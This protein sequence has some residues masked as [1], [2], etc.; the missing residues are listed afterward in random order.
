MPLKRVPKSALFFLV[1]LLSLV[2]CGS[3]E[4]QTLGI[5]A[6]TTTVSATSPTT[7]A[8]TTAPITSPATATTPPA[9]TQAATTR[10]ASTTA[11]KTT[12]A[13]P[14]AA[15]KTT[16]AS[17]TAAVKP[18]PTVSAGNGSGKLVIENVNREIEL[19]APGGG[20]RVLA[21]G[22]ATP[23]WSPD[24]K[25][26]AYTTLAN[27]GGNGHITTIKTIKEDGTGEETL[28]SGPFG[29]EPTWLLRW[30]PRGRYIAMYAR[31]TEIQDT[32]GQLVLCDV[33][34]KKFSLPLETAQGKPN[35]VFDWIPDG[36]FAFWQAGKDG[37]YNL[38]YGDPDKK[39]VDAIKLL[40]SQAI[41]SVN[42]NGVNGQG[43]FTSARFSP[44]GRTIAVAANQIGLF[45][46]PGGQRSPYEGKIFQAPKG[47]QLS[48]LPNG[49]M[50]AYLDPA[51]Q[52]V[53]TLDVTTGKA[54]AVAFN[55]LSFDWSRQ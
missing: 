26:I 14:T 43:Y 28:C 47:A 46:A 34:T 24:G 6:P 7:V 13:S 18:N 19:I 8:A 41:L 35:G 36:D 12:A 17:P 45:S 29:I 50:L 55:A 31:S 27:P 22:G 2:A 1:L 10:A 40:G 9:P 52:T 51:A 48:W 23:V 32:S 11:T 20:S 53:F 4:T 25:T 37:I 5:I 16:A 42:N 39:G 38:Y 49:R 44:D 21:Q 54:T 3:D 33:T 15:S 30:S